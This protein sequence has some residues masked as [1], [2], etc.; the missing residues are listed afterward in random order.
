[1]SYLKFDKNLLINLEQSLRLEVLRTNQSG[2]YHC[3][4]IVGANTRKQ[5]GLLVIPVPEIDDNSHVLLSSLDETVIQHGAP[6]NLGLH[7][8]SGGVY[9]P[10][11]HKYIREYDCE[12][13]PT[14]TFRVGGVILKREKIFITN[15]NRILIRYTLVDA[16]SKTTLQ[17]RPFLAFRNANDLCVENQVASRDYK[18]VSNG[19]STCMYDGYPEL[20][21]Q[22]NHKPKFVFDPHWYKGIEYIKDLERGIPYTED[23]YV[24]G[25]FEVDMKKGD[26]IIFSAGVSEVNTRQLTKMYEDEIKTRTPRTSFYNCL[27]NSAKQFYMTNADGHYLFAGYPWFKVRARDEFIAL[28][29][30]TLSNHHRPDF[31]AIMDTAK[32]AFTR[33]METGEPDK[34][35]QG[36][37]LPDVPLW[38]AWAIQRYSHDTDVPTARERYGEL[39]AQLIDF[40]IDGKHPNLQV[41]DNGLVRTDGTRQPMSWMDSAR[42]D[43]TPLI[44]RTGYLVE[45]N[46][47]WYNALM[48]LLQMYADDKQMQS[49][50]ERWQKISDVYAESFAPTF[51]NDY[52]YLYDYVNG[53]YTDLSVRPNMVIAVGVDHTPLDRRQRK[54]IL[55]F[56]TRELLTPKGLRTLSP[57]S[58]GYNPWYVGNPEQ[59]EKAYYSG[60]ARPWLMGFYCHAYVKV[61]GIGGLS[62]V[63]RMMIGF[64]DEMSQGAIGT[65][66]ELYDG[67]PPFIGRGAVSFAANVGEILRVLRLLKNLDV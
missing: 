12:R 52:G 39:V 23:L 59:R 50:V 58:Y 57:N 53:S 45:F 25:Y 19:I 5:H 6:F 20:F 51:L 61:F 7:R 67:N 66:S 65:L 18:E 14:H 55:D 8:Y 13:V 28:P 44:P 34:H 11:G 64:E 21:M 10:N 40:I 2:A 15:E 36:I 17:F 62:F 29:G 33:W 46:A 26:T 22:V 49:R 4:T 60:S 35:L 48:F 1:M 32:E 3:T 16:H 9:S 54:R 27:K 56:I 63:N 42:P 38:A 30:C 47:L 37:D 31:E 24:P 41:D 43:G